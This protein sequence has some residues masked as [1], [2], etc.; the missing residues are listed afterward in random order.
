LDG[1]TRVR[2]NLK[3]VVWPTSSVHRQDDCAMAQVVSRLASD[4]GK[5]SSM[6]DK[7]KCDLWWT[8]WQ[9]D[10]ISSQ[11]FGFPSS[12]SF[13]EY[14]T[15]IHLSTADAIQSLPTT[16]PLNNTLINTQTWHNMHCGW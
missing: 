16:V 6:P 5:Q 2:G 9:W 4:F 13:H 10:R 12:V 15:L 8:T 1:A 3:E 11:Y 14:S 7:Y